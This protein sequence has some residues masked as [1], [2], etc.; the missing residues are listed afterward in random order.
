MVALIHCGLS[1]CVC[2]FFLFAS[3][4][5]SSLLYS[6]IQFECV[7][8]LLLIYFLSSETTTNN[9]NESEETRKTR[10]YRRRTSCIIH[11]R[12]STSGTH[13]HRRRR[14][15]CRSAIIICQIVKEQTNTT[16]I[17]YSY[18]GFRTLLS[19]GAKRRMAS[20]NN[21]R[22]YFQCGKKTEKMWREKKQT[23]ELFGSARKRI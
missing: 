20:Q 16:G 23:S 2:V 4:C 17:M 3:L 14:H 21:D 10:K 11:R 7:Y 1:I 13:S 8:G 12:K 15:L 22:K 19:T 6:L 5:F 18:W 9:L